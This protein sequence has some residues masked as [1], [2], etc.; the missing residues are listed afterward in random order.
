MEVWY[1]CSLDG[2][3][4]YLPCKSQ[5]NRWQ[6]EENIRK[7]FSDMAKTI[8]VENQQQEINIKKR[9]DLS[10]PGWQA[11]PRK[12]SSGASLVKLPITNNTVI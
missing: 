4:T 12:A 9:H 6:Q 3:Y 11:N 5:S 1:C 10:G 8:L 2:Y 7:K